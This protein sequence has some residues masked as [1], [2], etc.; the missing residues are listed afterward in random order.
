MWMLHRTNEAPKKPKGEKNPKFP[1]DKN[2]ETVVAS[3][4]VQ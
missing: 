1:G 4:V 3:V 2:E